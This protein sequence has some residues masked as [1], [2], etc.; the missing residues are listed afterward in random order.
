VGT[1]AR[2]VG[3]IALAG[4]KVAPLQCSPGIQIQPPAVRRTRATS[5]WGERLLI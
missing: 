3:R 4:R 2:Q 5:P 1:A